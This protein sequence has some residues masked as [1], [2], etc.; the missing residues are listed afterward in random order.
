MVTFEQS[1]KQK[2]WVDKQTNSFVYKIL[3]TMDLGQL[4]S[5]IKNEK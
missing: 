4:D 1:N 5:L 3:E 2:S